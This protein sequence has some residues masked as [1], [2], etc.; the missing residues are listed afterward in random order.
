MVEMT[1]LLLPFEKCKWKQ[2]VARG[3][4]LIYARTRQN[5]SAGIINYYL[6][7]KLS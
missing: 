2:N 4:I 1:E 6:L 3:V 7:N 5:I